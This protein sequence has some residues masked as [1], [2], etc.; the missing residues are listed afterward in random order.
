MRIPS[1]IQLVFVVDKKKLYRKQ[2]VMDVHC[3]WHSHC[4][5]KAGRIHHPGADEITW[6]LSEF[7]KQ[8]V[9]KRYSVISNGFG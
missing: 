5:L 9:L 2:L 8:V 4:T 7:V 1:S 3:N 6:S